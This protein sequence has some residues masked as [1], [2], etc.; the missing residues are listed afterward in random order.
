MLKGHQLDR[1]FEVGLD[2]FMR[3][4]VVQAPHVPL[5]ARTVSPA[6]DHQNLGAVPVRL[7]YLQVDVALR[8][9]DQAG[10]IPKCRDEFV[11]SFWCDT[12]P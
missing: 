5:E 6:A 7:P 11:G 12:E 4:L 1:G 10:T 3:R 8:V 2:P 9:L